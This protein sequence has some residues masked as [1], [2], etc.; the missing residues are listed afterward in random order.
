MGSSTHSLICGWVW[1][2]QLFKL[3]KG[4]REPIPTSLVIY[5]AECDWPDPLSDQGPKSPGWAWL[6]IAIGIMLEMG[7]MLPIKRMNASGEVFLI[8]LSSY[9]DAQLHRVTISEWSDS[10]SRLVGQLQSLVKGDFIP[11]T[12]RV[13]TR[14]LYMLGE[15]QINSGLQLR[16]RYPRQREVLQYIQGAITSGR[17][18]PDLNISHSGQWISDRNQTLDW[19]QRLI[20]ARVAARSLRNGR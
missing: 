18:L 4:S 2:H 12:N 19:Q 3:A 14:S 8:W 15:T 1:R 20:N 13:R 16:P 5:F 6:E 9:A 17:S 11:P 10:A 7:A